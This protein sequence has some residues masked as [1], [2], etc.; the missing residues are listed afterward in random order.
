MA[1]VQHS[2]IKSKLLELVAPLVDTSGI[3]AKSGPGREAHILSRPIA[4]AAIK[5]LADVDY[6]VAANAI[7]DGE[8]DNGLDA[9]YYD[10]QNKTLFLVQSK[11]SNTHTSAVESG[12][13]LKFP[14]GVQDL[15]SLKK[16]RF[17]E[18][19][20]KRWNLIEDALTKLASARLVVAYSGSGKLSSDSG[21]DK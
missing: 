6:A 13:I 20:Q 19:V 9:I 21:Q 4:V 2:Q 8:K 11:W 1:E 12:D 7:V 5:M 14:Q 17:N 15:I 18:K 10:P 16:N 3:A